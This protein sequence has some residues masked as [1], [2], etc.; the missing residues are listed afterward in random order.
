MV[1]SKRRADVVTLISVR[2]L[3]RFSGLQTC[4]GASLFRARVTPEVS[5]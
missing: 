3:R 4:D 2:A 1:T 5:G